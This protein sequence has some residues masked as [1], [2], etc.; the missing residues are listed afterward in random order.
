MIE[1]NYIFLT[2][3]KILSPNKD[4]S[5]IKFIF[6]NIY[7]Y[8]HPRVYILIPGYCTYHWRENSS[9]ATNLVLYITVEGIY[10]KLI[11]IKYMIMQY[12]IK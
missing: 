4:P 12:Y 9:L 10:C 3:S 7:T 2:L 1:E 8:T 5:D 6:I 11:Y